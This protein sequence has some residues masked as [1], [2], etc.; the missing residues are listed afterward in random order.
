MEHCESCEKELNDE[1]T[2]HL[3]DVDICLDCSY[4]LT[5]EALSIPELVIIIHDNARAKGFWD[6]DRDIATML[7]LIVSEAAEAM[8]ADRNNIPE[9]TEGCLS[10]EL[11]DII[12]RTL[13]MAAGLKLD[14]GAAIVKKI[15]KNKTR[16]HMHGKK[17]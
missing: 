13:D 11:A 1:N 9:G 4:G 2:V 15:K 10:E 17:Y 12:I 16:Q 7:M 6:K 3:A 8:E 14:I 5:A